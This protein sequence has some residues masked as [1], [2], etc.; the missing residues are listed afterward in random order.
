[1]RIV[2]PISKILLAVKN[3]GQRRQPGVDKA[4]GIA[5]LLGAR[6]E[7]FHALSAPVFVDL[8]PRS[9]LGLVASK[10]QLLAR[11]QAQLEKLAVQA[12][13]H[14]IEASAAVE[15]DF[16]PHE[17]VVRRAAKTGADLIIAE[18]HQG[19]RLLPWLVHLTDWELLRLAPL[20][21]L[22]LKNGRP[23][24]R[25]KILA[26]VD[27]SHAHD[28]PARL[29]GEILEQAGRLS[30]A[31]RGSLT[32]MHANAPWSLGLVLGDPALDASTIA[33]TFEQMQMRGRRRFE[34]FARRRR[35][36]RART[37]VVDNDP[38]LA[39]PLY[40]RQMG[41]DV[42]VMGAVSRSGL[43]RMF[44]GNTAER[45][46]ADLPCDVLVIKPPRF[47][48]KVPRRPRGARVL[49]PPALVPLPI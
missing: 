20:P 19:P 11:H 3:P 16:P 22:V 14:G 49:P 47:K 40:A 12:R 30:N 17:A 7:L 34:D 24:K 28:K 33:M 39:I 45:V 26:A 6:L 4:A 8:D 5:R 41:A 2:K 25:P 23:W 44:I 32:V 42:V 27:P 18:C 37:R 21:V 38:V 1:M 29:D 31:T 13:R 35:V 10:R 43:K 48:S 36:P 46:L 9:G 15:W